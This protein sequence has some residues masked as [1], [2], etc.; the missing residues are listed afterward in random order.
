MDKRYKSF[1]HEER[2]TIQEMW[3]AG[4]MVKEIAEE[5]QAPVRTVYSE[6][7]RGR[8]ESCQR[9]P[10]QRI[11]YNADLAQLRLQQSF[12]RRGRRA[13]VSLGKGA[14]GDQL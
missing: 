4:K 1:T 8:P 6:L 7:I 11:A 9:L 10:N 2:K 3:E 12:E 14:E 5:L 13:G